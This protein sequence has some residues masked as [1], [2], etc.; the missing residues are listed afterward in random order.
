M[1]SEEPW[2]ETMSEAG[3]TSPID[4]AAV[5]RCPETGSLLQC[6]GDDLVA[7]DGEQRYP[8]RDGIPCFL[9][10]EPVEDDRA[11]S[12]LEDLNRLAT[13]HGW[14]QALNKVYGADADIIKYVTDESRAG[15]LNLL[16]LDAGHSVL[17][18]GPGLGQ[19]SPIIGRRVKHL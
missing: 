3:I 7:T 5:F 8:A 11:R 14:R 16:D 4:F 19:F 12:G 6:E 9:S 15:F 17:E 1:T 18:I 2:Y 13:E 10:G